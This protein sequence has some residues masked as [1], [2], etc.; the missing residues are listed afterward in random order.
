MA[1]SMYN[2]VLK[3]KIDDLVLFVKD[4][5]VEVDLN[6]FKAISEERAVRKGRTARKNWGDASVA[7]D[8]FKEQQWCPA[9]NAHTQAVGD[10]LGALGYR[11]DFYITSNLVL[12]HKKVVAKIYV[13]LSEIIAKAEPE[14]TKTKAKAKK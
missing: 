5:T 6:G 12:T 8:S 3:E 13:T 11:G 2:S 14:E 4:D 1:N 7:M 9:N 10:V